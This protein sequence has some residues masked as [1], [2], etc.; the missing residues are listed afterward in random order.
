MTYKIKVEAFEGPFDLLFH[1]IEKNE[2]DIYDI[3]ISEITVQYIQYLKAMQEMDLNVTSEF[4]VMVATLLEIKSKMLLPIEKKE[5]HQ[6]EFEEAD[7][8]NELVRKLLEYKKYKYIAEALK[9]KSD[10]S[11]RLYFKPREEIIFDNEEDKSLLEDMDMY[12][13]ILALEK[14]LTQKSKD[15][16]KMH[17]RK[18]ERDAFTVEEKINT[19]IATLSE[20]SK[21]TFSGLF[22]PLKSR[23][24]V[25]TTFLALLELIKMKRI[26]VKQSNCFNEILIEQKK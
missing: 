24:E 12:Q 19:I 21:V 14:V 2:I 20:K 4:L 25:I 6:I 8:R 16:A 18:M 10:L 1:L 23:N 9:E 22:S 13:L 17:F 5:D 7:P 3:P 11:K 15:E 26:I